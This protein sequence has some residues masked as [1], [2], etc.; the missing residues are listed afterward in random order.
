MFIGIF[1]QLGGIFSIFN[2]E[3]F[4]FV[5]IE[6][7]EEEDKENDKIEEILNDLIFEN[8]VNYYLFS[9]IVSFFIVGLVYQCSCGYYRQLFFS[10]GLGIFYLC[11]EQIDLFDFNRQDLIYYC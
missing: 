10:Q 6:G 8:K 3:E 7:L 4:L 11:L 1:D 9:I 2:I 5:E